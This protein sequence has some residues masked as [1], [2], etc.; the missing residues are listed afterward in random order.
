[1]DA[2]SLSPKHRHQPRCRLAG[3]RAIRSHQ[4]PPIAM[5]NPT[6]CWNCRRH[7]EP[8]AQSSKRKCTIL[9]MVLCCCRS[10]RSAPI[11]A[12]SGDRIGWSGVEFAGRLLRFAGRL[13]LGWTIEDWRLLQLRR[14]EPCL[15]CRYGL[16]PSAIGSRCLQ[17]IW[18]GWESVLLKC[19]RR[20]D[21]GVKRC[22]GLNER[23]YIRKVGW[24][25][26]NVASRSCLGH[27]IGDATKRNGESSCA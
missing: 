8:P 9:R 4:C 10:R 1:M 27:G 22:R 3:H 6:H 15:G 12:V 20:R 13:D 18:P 5:S 21:N 17:L 2:R 16:R 24:N 11:R 23:S 19:F 7:A 14:L 26:G 25:R